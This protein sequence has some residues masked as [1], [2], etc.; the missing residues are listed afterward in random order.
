MPSRRQPL[1]KSKATIGEL[2]NE[3]PSARPIPNV[4][5]EVIERIKKCFAHANHKNANEQE[6][7][8]AIMM[9]SRIM[10]KYKISQAEVMLHEN[11]QLRATRGGIST[12]NVWPA[13]SS[14]RPFIP[15]WTE[16]LY[17]ALEGFFGCRTFSTRYDDRIRYTFYGIA[18]HT[19]AAAVNFEAVHN[20]I[21]DWSE[22]FTGVSTRNSYCLGVTD[23]LLA[24]S[25][26]EQKAT[27]KKAREVESGALATRMKEE[28]K[29][30]QERIARLRTQ[31]LEPILESDAEI[32]SDENDDV[33][34]TA[35]DHSEFGAVRGDSPDDEVMSDDEV[36]PDFA[37][38]GPDATS[39]VDTNADF[40][41]ELQKFIPS[42]SQ[43]PSA[44]QGEKIRRRK[45]TGI[46]PSIENADEDISTSDPLAEWKSMRQLSVFRSMSR[47]V[48][49][50]VLEENNIKI[51]TIKRGPKSIR[52]KHAFKE[53]KEDSK[54]INVRA[55]RIEPGEK[56][57]A[58]AIDLMECS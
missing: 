42:K 13:K 32:E 3:N 21:L 22:K 30:E 29:E 12:V 27:E 39:T 10:E 33:S 4:G 56:Q 46:H 14:G 31:P 57:A 37:D 47:E 49:D 20:Q 23:G 54:K 43:K 5:I 48:E 16:W 40:D 38:K 45:D 53:G 55:A 6:A 19:V 58:E 25:R 24:L 35:G 9:A 18:E 28:E 26:E 44:Q 15:G 1:L 17:G 51:R 41:A 8:A 52:D 11:S 7:R 50:K 34:M 36:L 2:A